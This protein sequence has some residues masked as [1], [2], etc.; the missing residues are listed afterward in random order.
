MAKGM[1]VK[2]QYEVSIDPDT[3]AEIT[4]LTPPEVTCHRN[5]FYQKCFFN[6]GSHLLFA[7]EFDGHWNYYLLNLAQAEAVQLTEGAG[8]NTFGG[9]LSP[10]DNYL[11][12]VK[13]DRVLREVNLT[14]LAERDVYRVPEDWVGYGTWVANSDCTKLVGIEIA[15]S[16]YVPL[17]DW[18]IFHDF[19]HK[20]PHCR[21]LRVDLQTGASETIH[22]E[23]IWLGHPI[24][25]PFDD[26]TVAFCHEGPHDLV[27]ARMWMVNEDGSNVR[28]V[29]EHADGESCTH[30]FWVPDGSALIYVSYLKGQQGRT[31]Y[32]Y[33]P[34]SG[35]NEEVM[36]MPACSHLMSNFDG[37][38][39]V[40]DGSGTP[41]DVK[42][43]SGYTIE[44]DPYLYV[45]DVAQKAY[46][47]VARHDTSWDTFA[48]SRQV[49][50][51]HP[52]FTPDGNAILFSTDKDGKPAVYIAKLPE[53]R[54]MLKVS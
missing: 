30:E 34:D 36:P 48:G 4:R 24:Y 43:T 39:L 15:K 23:K 5:Y 6:D 2:L 9:F 42:D 37:T 10:D 44:N 33:L 49:T 21:L 40:G 22:E 13:N 28:K 17:S 35:V 53:Q 19:F 31:I 3:G 41:V 11:Y 50:H 38:L 8:D 12:Y 25:R 18:K 29:K 54:E 46:Y 26:N 20:G 7:G 51:P 32:R 14:T 1:R 52:S 16:D 27:D 45:F 47:R